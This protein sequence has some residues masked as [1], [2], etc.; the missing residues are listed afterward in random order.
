MLQN[1][2]TGLTNCLYMTSLQKDFK[3]VICNGKTFSQKNVVQ[4]LV[5]RTHGNRNWNNRSNI[6]EFPQLCLVTYL[7]PFCRRNHFIQT[8]LTGNTGVCIFVF[9]AQQTSLQLIYF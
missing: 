9:T 4:L 1:T 8:K 3:C 7:A 5:C 6:T 2:S